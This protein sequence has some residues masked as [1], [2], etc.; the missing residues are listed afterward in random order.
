M[1]FFSDRSEII[2]SS[3]Y[4]LKCHPEQLTN[5]LKISSDYKGTMRRMA[6]DGLCRLPPNQAEKKEPVK[7]ENQEESRRNQKQPGPK[8]LW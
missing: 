3:D 7:P 2:H 4:F 5:C 6:V 8:G 1:I